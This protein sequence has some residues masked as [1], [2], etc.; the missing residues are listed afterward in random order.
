MAER[1]EIQSCRGT[2]AGYAQ[3][4]ER[5]G[6]LEAYIGQRQRPDQIPLCATHLSIVTGRPLIT[7][8]EL[9][10]SPHAEVVGRVGP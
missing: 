1:C 2:S 4:R 8:L 6:P 10:A 9:F 3:A 5:G 7:R